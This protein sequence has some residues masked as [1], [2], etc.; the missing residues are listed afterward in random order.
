MAVV[1]KRARMEVIRREG[2]SEA[3]IIAV[4]APF[5]IMASAYGPCMRKRCEEHEEIMMMGRHAAVIA[6]RYHA[7][8]MT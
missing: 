2:A 6:A 1:A 3:R 7:G 4:R 5:V 8:E